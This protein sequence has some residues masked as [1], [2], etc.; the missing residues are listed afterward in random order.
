MQIENVDRRIHSVRVF[1]SLYFKYI[2]FSEKFT[3]LPLVLAK[4]N[5]HPSIFSINK[6]SPA[7]KFCLA[8]VK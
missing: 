6:T 8:A 4:R 2:R 3:Y 1:V 7:V 5:R